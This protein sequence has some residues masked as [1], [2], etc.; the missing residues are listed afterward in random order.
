MKI[1]FTDLVMGLIFGTLLYFFLFKATSKIEIPIILYFGYSMALLLSF[2]ILFLS[3][4]KLWT[5]YFT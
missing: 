5:Y 1:Y 4:R 2:Y 3:W